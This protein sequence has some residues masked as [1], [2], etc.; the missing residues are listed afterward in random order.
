MKCHHKNSFLFSE[1]NKHYSERG[2][3]PIELKSLV[4]RYN[5]SFRQVGMQIKRIFDPISKVYYH[6]LAGTFDD[7][8]S[9]M[10]TW[11]QKESSLYFL[12][13][14]EI[15]SH[16]MRNVNEEDEINDP[17]SVDYS[18]LSILTRTAL[19]FSR[20]VQGGITM[21]LAEKYFSLWIP[22]QWFQYIDSKSRIA[23][24]ARTLSLM[25]NYL[26]SKF[27]IS[28]C[29]ICNFTCLI[30]IAC[31]KCQLCMHYHCLENNTAKGQPC[32][33]C[34]VPMSDVHYILPKESNEAMEVEE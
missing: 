13:L 24:G 6:V 4:K 19:N 29:N 11:S 31:P 16:F 9:K 21:A 10:N 3:Q 34:N 20:Q 7:R 17:E 26:H 23:V 12:V 14:D 33:N 15:I 32:P 27:S 1:Y 8:L 28:L 18:S 25:S 5:I 30:G 2:S 22:Q